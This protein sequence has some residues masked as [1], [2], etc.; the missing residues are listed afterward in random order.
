[1]LYIDISH[2]YMASFNIEEVGYSNLCNLV[3]PL[4]SY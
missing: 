3:S 2:I 1:M 4:G